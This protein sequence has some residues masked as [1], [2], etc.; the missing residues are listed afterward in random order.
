MLRLNA[1]Q[2]QILTDK[3]PDVAHLVTAAIAIGFLVGEPRASA[4]L[5]IVTVAAWTAVLLVAL[6]VGR[7]DS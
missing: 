6:L 4:R 7:E 3:V 1:R 5:F 2:R